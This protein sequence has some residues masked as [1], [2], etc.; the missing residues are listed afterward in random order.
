MDSNSTN[1]NETS[2]D[3]TKVKDDLIK[4]VEKLRIELQA[5]NEELTKEKEEKQVHLLFASVHMN[6]LP[7]C[8]EIVSRF[9]FGNVTIEFQP[10]QHGNGF[11]NSNIG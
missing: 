10:Y 9:G 11:L 6:K 3:D 8:S 1:Y 4:L 2:A 5:K 7:L